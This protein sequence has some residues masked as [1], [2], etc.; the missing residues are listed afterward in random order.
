MIWS[1]NLRLGLPHGD[2][3]QILD[4]D[5][6]TQS[7]HEADRAAV[8][9]ALLKPGSK[10]RNERGALAVAQFKSISRQVWPL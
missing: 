3:D 9:E 8:T 7:I 2:P 5:L 6:N 4:E 1:E 10:A